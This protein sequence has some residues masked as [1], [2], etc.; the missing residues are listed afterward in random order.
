MPCIMFKVFFIV[1]KY[2]LVDIFECIAVIAFVSLEIKNSITYSIRITYYHS[3]PSPHLCMIH[4]NCADILFY[5]FKNMLN[6][7]AIG[8]KKFKVKKHQHREKRR[9]IL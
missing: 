2:F 1:F 6:E 7:G 9:Y 5:Q 4:T 3:V 8:N